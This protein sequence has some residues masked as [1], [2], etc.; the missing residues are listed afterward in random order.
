MAIFY[1][2][3]EGAAQSKLVREAEASSH[4]PDK[5]IVDLVIEDGFL[6]AEQF[7]VV[8]EADEN[9][10]DASTRFDPAVVGYCHA[11]AAS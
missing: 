11:E 10:I 8:V 3:G 5:C 6:R 9:E 4:M 7:C 1:V 2:W